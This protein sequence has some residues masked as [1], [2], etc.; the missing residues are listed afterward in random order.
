LDSIAKSEGL[1]SIA[2]S[3]GL[4]SKNSHVGWAKSF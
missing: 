4:D 1:D 3:E 2:K